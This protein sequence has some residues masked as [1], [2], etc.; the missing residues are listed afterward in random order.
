VLGVGVG[1]T[2]TVSVLGREIEARIASLREIHW[3]TMG[4]NYLIVFPPSV[5][6]AA[7][8]SLAATI[9]I[10]KR[11]EG[12]VSRAVVGAFP[13]ASVIDVGEII[14]R[15]GTPLG[16]MSAA[17]P[18]SASVAIPGRHRRFD[19]RDRRGAGGALL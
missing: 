11:Q 15:V 1:D 6:E 19:R 8:H 5:L 12:A 18:L 13:S 10:E 4:F 3:D 2:L 9:G 16:Q 14:T 7:P 17:I